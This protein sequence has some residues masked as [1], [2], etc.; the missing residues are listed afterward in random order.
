MGRKS[1]V[2]RTGRL[3]PPLDKARLER[4]IR[5]LAGENADGKLADDVYLERKRQLRSQIEALERSARP[6]IPAAR[7]VDWL[8]ALS[9]TWHAADVEEEKADLLQAIDDRIVVSG[10]GSSRPAHVRCAG[11][12]TDPCTASGCNGAP[13]RT[14]TCDLWVRNPT[15]YPLSYRR[16][17]R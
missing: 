17:S 14:R 9:E 11:P 10:I 7:T 6:G 3:K 15:L 2:A 13:D 12:W 16:A 5:V 8:R 4:Q 1:G